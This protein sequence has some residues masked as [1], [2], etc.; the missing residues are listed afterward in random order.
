MSI[1]DPIR[2][3]Q[4]TSRNKIEQQEHCDDAAARRIIIVD[5][6]GNILGGVKS[7]IDESG[8][9]ISPLQTNITLSN[10]VVTAI[11]VGSSNLNKRTTIQ[12]QVKSGTIWYG[13][14]NTITSGTN[15]SGFR[16]TKNDIISV[17]IGPEKD[18]YVISS[19]NTTKIAIA[20]L[21]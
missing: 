6:N 4:I 8:N 21:P 20:E 9:I 13:Y 7:V 10:G 17:D 16:A 15:G 11:R 5:H 19:N 1:D 3:N 14:I 12:V 2:K 18:F